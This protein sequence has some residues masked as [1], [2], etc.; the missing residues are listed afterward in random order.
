MAK[1][2]YHQYSERRERP[3]K[4]AYWV[5]TERTASTKDT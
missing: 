4:T 1:R 2:V 3:E 5:R